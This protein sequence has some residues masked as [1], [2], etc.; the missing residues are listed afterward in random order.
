MFGSASRDH[1][2]AA[3]KGAGMSANHRSPKSSVVIA[4]LLGSEGFSEHVQNMVEKYWMRNVCRGGRRKYRNLD[5]EITEMCKKLT[6]AEKLILG[7]FIS[8]H[9][10]MSF[11]TGLRIGLTT[12]A[13]K[14]AQDVMSEEER[15][16]LD[17]PKTWEGLSED[18]P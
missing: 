2:A 7:R 12:F 13:A 1:P 5:K 4:K 8:L 16:R 14:N 15:M 17:D 11:D 6:D 9:K 3:G 18:A 10:K